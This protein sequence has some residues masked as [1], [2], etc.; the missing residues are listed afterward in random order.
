MIIKGHGQV[1]FEKK[2]S[3][4]PLYTLGVEG[5]SLRVRGTGLSLTAS[6]S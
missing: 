6:E 4:V 2:Y 3:E 5:K 1:A